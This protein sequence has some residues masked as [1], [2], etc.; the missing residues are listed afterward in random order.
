MIMRSMKLK[1]SWIR[2]RN[3][4]RSS[5]WSSGQDTQTNS[6]LGYLKKTWATRK[7]LLTLLI[8]ETMIINLEGIPVFMSICL[9]QGCRY[10]EYVIIPQFPGNQKDNLS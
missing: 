9:K 8:I 7:S 4:K 2:N 6:T 1:E 3:A 10:S 5:I